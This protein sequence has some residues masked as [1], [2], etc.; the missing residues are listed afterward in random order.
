VVESIR[1]SVTGPWL[2]A[3]R[4]AGTHSLAIWAPLTVGWVLIVGFR[5]HALAFD[6]HQAYLP[7]ARAVLDGDSPFPPATVAALSPKTAFVYPPLAA[8]LAVP[9]AVV[10][11]LVADILVS[12]LAIGCVLLILRVLDVRDWRCYMI[13]FLWVPTYSAIQTANVTLL[14]ALGLA[15]IW[16]YRNRTAAVSLLVGF[17]IALK[18]FLWP[19]LVWAIATR[20]Y[21]AAAGGVATA[22]VLVFGPWAAIGFDGLAQYPHLL[23]T[24]SRLQRL[25]GYT[26]AALLEP[27][28]SWRVGQIVGLAVGLVILA[29]AFVSGRID[30]RKSLA[31]TVAA[32]LLLSPIVSLHYFVF[33]LVVLG[34]YL[35][36]F[37]PVWVVPLLFWASP[38]VENGA[39]W[40]TGA[41]LV[42]AAAVFVLALGLH[43]D[44][45]LAPSIRDAAH[46]P[47]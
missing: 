32:I 33:L 39:A 44:R 47:T 8:F 10:P 31:L 5:Q 9:F 41:A 16:R 13:A 37:G 12:L 11:T 23:D 7:A 29:L 38:Q 20:R 30:E 35:P 22:L 1:N 18:L 40:Q 43:R 45:A 26:I 21:R 17:L 3:A 28:L 14:M 4:R 34:L 25:D 42:V 36:R 6:F 24:L 46:V 2:D 15:L 27:A 19:L